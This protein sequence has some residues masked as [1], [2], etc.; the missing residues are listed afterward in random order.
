MISK[1]L[2]PAL[3]SRGP[4]QLYLACQELFAGD[5]RRRQKNNRWRIIWPNRRRRE[6]KLI[7][8]FGTG[9]VPLGADFLPHVFTHLVGSS[10]QW[11]WE[12]IL[13]RSWQLEPPEDPLFVHHEYD[14]RSSAPF[15]T[16]VDFFGSIYGIPA[17][18]HTRCI[19]ELLE[20]F[21]LTQ[22]RHEKAVFHDAQ[23]TAP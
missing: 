4:R 22:H 11:N 20:F 14:K 21:D 1:I 15:I 3:L 9:K 5:Q 13:A 17:A 7:D 18:E 12:G 2:S 23:R 16:A 6:D 10:D 8:L 19:D